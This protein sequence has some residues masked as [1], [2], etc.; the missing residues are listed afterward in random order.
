MK[1]YDVRGK[2]VLITGA[3]SGIGQQ[4]SH[5]FARE[6]AVLFL[7]CHPGEK[8]VLADW[9]GELRACYGSTVSIFPVDLSTKSGPDRLY[10]Q[11]VKRAKRLDV[12]VNN[13]GLMAYGNFHEIPME[14]QEVMLMVNL[15]AYS[16]LMHRALADMMSRGEGRI[17]NVSSV[18]AFQPTA[19]HAV[20]GAAK[21]FIQSLSEAVDTE[22]AGSGVVV[23]TLN[24]SYTDTPLLRGEGFPRRIRWYRISGLNSPER[25]AEKGFRAFRRGRRIYIPG[26]RNAL[27]HSFL[28]RILPRRLSNAIAYF[29]L[30]GA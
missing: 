3:S 9:A 4:L 27:I 25:I 19:H 8:R 5:C 23:C 24:P 11:V 2:R 14:R 28:P 13:A 15:R 7:G 26:L 21:A 29:V 6:G 12:L 16:R 22:I 10:R 17:L 18:S 30:K 1:Q 20:Y